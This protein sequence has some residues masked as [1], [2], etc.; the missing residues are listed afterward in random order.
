MNQADIESTPEDTANSFASQAIRKASLARYYL[1]LADRFASLLEQSDGSLEGLV[2]DEGIRQHLLT[3]VGLS[4]KAKKYFTSDSEEDHLLEI[5]K[6]LN[7]DNTDLKRELL[8]RFLLTSGDSLGGRSR[9]LI[10]REGSDRL[11]DTVLSVLEG[12]AV[13]F[14]LSKPKGEKV[15]AIL[16][17]E[18]VLLLDAKPRWIN[19]NIDVILLRFKGEED[20]ASLR[21]NP[22]SFLA[23]GE[24]KG[25]ADPAG[26]DEHWKTAKSALDRI[27]DAFSA[28]QEPTPPLFFAGQAIVSG[29]AQEIV[30]DLNRGKLAKAA[31]LARENQ[32]RDLANWLISL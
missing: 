13:P 20:L 16:W 23:C 1:N 31:N 2:A 10:G 15:G 5:L 27:R 25:G 14:K 18:R 22:A 7:G 8:F 9:N 3:A 29:V 30:T 17:D 28:L 6:T 12:K 24:I 19:K 21:E 26:S 4:D 32:V 11:I